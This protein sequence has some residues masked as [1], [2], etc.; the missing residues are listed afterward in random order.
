MRILQINKFL[1]LKGGA[2]TYALSLIELLKKNN[3]EVICF[4]QKNNKNIPCSEA[5]YFIDDL[6]L[7][8]FSLPSILKLPRIFWSFKARRLVKK[9]IADKRPDIV[10][11]HNIYHQISPSILPIFRQAGIPVVMT[12]HD[13]K[14]ITPNYTLRADG[15][16]LPHKGSLLIDLALRLEF[17]WH[18]WL[19]VYKNNI[20]LYIA[21]SQ[22]VKNKL[23]ENGFDENKISVT[24]HFLAEEFILPKN[25]ESTTVA[26]AT[27]TGQ[28]KYIFSYGRLDEGK[29]FDDLIKAYAEIN[30]LGLK[31]KIAGSGPDEDRLNKIAENLGLENRVELL[32]QKTRAEIIELIKGAEAV[33]SC[34][35]LHETFGLTV[36]E[37]MATGKPV[38]AS[39]VGAIPELIE[40]GIN[41]LLYQVSDAGDLKKQL[42]KLLS[43]KELSKNLAAAARLAAEKYSAENHYAE[44]IRIYEQAIKNFKKP[45]RLI[46]IGVIN[47]IAFLILT[48]LLLIPFYNIYIENSQALAPYAA[49]YPRLANLYWKNP[50]TMADA[51]ELAKWDL[52]VLDMQTQ[53]NSVAAINEIRRLNPN[54]IILAYTTA[55]EMMVGQLKNVEPS[56]AGL[57]HDL[58]SGDQNVWH[59]K[60]YRGEDVVFWPGNVMMN[61]GVRDSNG[62]TYADYLVDF[63]DQRLMRNGL[64]DGLLFDNTWQTVSQVSK[65]IDIDG[66]GRPDTTDKINSLWQNY[67][68][69]F[70][71]KLRN[72]LGSRAIILGNGDGAYQQYLNGRMFEGFPEYWEGGWTGSIKRYN[73]TEKSGFQPRI[74][75]INSDTSNTGNF[76]DYQSMRYGLTS[77]L[78][79]NGYYSFDYGTQLREQFWWYDEYDAKL[80]QPAG[81]AKNL[82]SQSSDIQPGAWQRDFTGGIVLVNS[83]DKPQTIIFDAD[84]EKLRGSQ[85]NKTNS[86]NIINKITLPANDGI[87]LLK[88]VS[89]INNSVFVNGAYARVFDGSGKVKRTGFFAYSTLYAGGANIIKIDLNGDKERETFVA[90]KGAIKLFDK[91]NILIKTVYPYGEKF[92][93]QISLAVDKSTVIAAPQIGGSNLIRFYDKNLS[94][95][96]KSFNAYSPLWKNLGASVAACDTDGDGKT[97]IITGAGFGG[98]P[99]VKVFNDE[100]KVIAEWFAYGLNFRGGVNVA[101]ADLNNDGKAEVI[102][103][104]GFSGGPHVKVF[105]GN[106]KLINE[107]FAYD[108]NKRQG[109]KVT[110]ADIDGDGIAEVIALN[111]NVF[112]K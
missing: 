112:G 18:K 37:A 31:L 46:N 2:E 65:D 88:P 78:L 11:I 100:N 13:F 26:A 6:D 19:N 16:Y 90:D 82:L 103:G 98:G 17:V 56:G 110:T 28:E 24:P 7:S 104:A 58:A 111:L 42:Q 92:T 44:L 30:V 39:K 93:G 63:Y 67:F 72:R 97:E 108:M 4:S 22:F 74:N 48:I 61:L 43:N 23:V 55:N 64:W 71:S 52:L 3:Q 51:Q 53:T 99:H 89:N 77:A 101:C 1:Y 75:I 21:P 41:G 66:D 50:V 73:E 10:H 32:G 35:K 105:D 60:T 5:Q 87:I 27:E 91:N 33:I 95:A 80:G 12:V 106:G 15:K 54:I 70:F 47:I 20:D 49:D 81:A 34:S 107:W 86:G 36:L 84:Y 40:D 76:Y 38:I 8:K 25:N 68:S 45:I 59:L 83:T 62:R 29:G 69:E 57:W 96:G 102:T 85:D 109:V 14:L 9:L 79:F 94:E